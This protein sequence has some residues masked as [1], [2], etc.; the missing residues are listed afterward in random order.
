MLPAIYKASERATYK[1]TN[2]SN[3]PPITRSV[4]RGQHGTYPMKNPG[5]GEAMRRELLI[6]ESLFLVYSWYIFIVRRL[7]LLN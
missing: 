5:I 2:K 4:I 3:A 6:N 7:A 1:A